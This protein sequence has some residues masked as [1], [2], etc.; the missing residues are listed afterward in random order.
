MSEMILF[1]SDVGQTQM[2]LRAKSGT[3][4]LSQ[5]EIAKLF[6]TTKQNVSLHA[7]NNHDLI[8]AIEDS[9]V[10]TLSP[11]FDLLKFSAPLAPLRGEGSGERGR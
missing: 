9:I 7:K 2:H 8:L 6:Q 4:W 11:Q 5:A 1:T 3:I 10:G